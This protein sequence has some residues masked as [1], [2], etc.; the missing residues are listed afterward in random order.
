MI[1]KAIAAA[2]E[3]VVDD[4]VRLERKLD[5]TIQRAA[6]RLDMLERTPGPQGVPGTKGDP[7]ERGE[8]GEPGASTTG[9]KGDPGAPGEK[10]ERGEPGRDADPDTIT[11]ALL[12]NKEFVELT[13]GRDGKDGNDGAGIDTPEWQAGAVYRKGVIVVAH[14]GQHFRAL[15]D[16]ASNV[17]DAEH[18]QRIGTSGFRYCG[19]F[20]ADATYR[21]GDLVVRDYSTFCVV[22][23]SLVLF[24]ARGSVGQ[25]GERGS[26]G[27]RG[28]DGRDG[29]LI[30]T[31]EVK[32]FKLVIL[33]ESAKG[34]QTF[35]ADF[36]PAFRGVLKDALVQ[37]RKEMA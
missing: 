28:K 17:D 16:T 20:K 2:L 7:G 29:A 35:E 11:N 3:P 1:E 6:E 30:L 33:Q 14:I 25:K 23:G 8:K 15:Q 32:G 31:T 34:I 13:K 4:L 37:L 22:R 36:G 18:W 21:D 10:G 27:E 26:Q 9:E 19:A 24:S 5:T 12:A